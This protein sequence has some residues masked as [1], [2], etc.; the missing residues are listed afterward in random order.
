MATVEWGKNPSGQGKIR[1][2]ADC[3]EKTEVGQLGGK[4]TAQEDS[5]GL[6]ILWGGKDGGCYSS[7][8]TG[9]AQSHRQD[10]HQLAGRV[11]LVQQGAR[12]CFEDAS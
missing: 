6:E 3:Q 4:K 2:S 7:L 1:I 5:S 11:L 9:T 8:V 10:Y 12:S